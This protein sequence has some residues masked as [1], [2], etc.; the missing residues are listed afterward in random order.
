MTQETSRLHEHSEVR[1]FFSLSATK[2]GRGP[3]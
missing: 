2:W 1:D 3:G